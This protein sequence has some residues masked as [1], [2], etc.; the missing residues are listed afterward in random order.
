MDQNRRSFLMN[1]GKLV[2]GTTLL[3]ALPLEIIY[4]KRR[5]VSANDK[6]QM[7]LIGCNGMGWSDLTAHLKIPDVE[8]VALC[9][10]DENVLNK[11]AAEL[12]KITGKK[13]K[14]YKDFRKLLQDKDI[15]AVIIRHTRSLALPDDDCCLRSRGKTF[16]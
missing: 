4:A 11:R 14:L 9:D 1:S 2:A 16:M 8:F 12:E 3:S 10:V 15:D 6:I 5:K 13:P 7:A